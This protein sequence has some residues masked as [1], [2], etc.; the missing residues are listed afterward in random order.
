MV[1]SN[2]RT[3]RWAAILLVAACSTQND[4]DVPPEN[5]LTGHLQ[6]FV[7]ATGGTL[8]SC[9]VDGVVKQLTAFF[10]GLNAGDA[11]IAGSFF[12][13]GSIRDFRWFSF[14]DRDAGGPGHFTTFTPDSIDEYFTSRHAAGDRFALRGARFTSGGEDNTLS[15]SPVL[16]DYSVIDPESHAVVL[17]YGVGKGR[18]NC[19]AALFDGMSLGA[20]LDGGQW[21][22]LWAGLEARASE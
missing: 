4:V 13:D 1:A 11:N 6:R 9:D 20:E 19:E 3:H 21:S 15:F 8:T 2:F 16:F 12:T 7:D 17:H 5:P 18:Y 22:R 10:A 14:T